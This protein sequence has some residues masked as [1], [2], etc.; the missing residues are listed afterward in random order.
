MNPITQGISQLG[1]NLGLPGMGIS[2][3]VGT[4]WSVA[5]SPQNVYHPPSSG[6]V[7]P[8]GQPYSQGL[9]FNPQGS[10]ANYNQMQNSGGLQFSNP[11][12][13]VQGAQTQTSSNNGNYFNTQQ[14]KGVLNGQ[15]YTDYNAY[16]RAGGQPN[17]GGIQQVNPDDINNAYNEASGFYDQLYNQNADPTV[18]QNYVDQFT[19]PYDAESQ[20]LGSSYQQ[21]QALNQNQQSQTRQ[22]QLNAL[23]A[24]KKQYNELAQGVQQRYGGSNSAGEFANAFLGRQFQQNSGNIQNTTGQNLQSL[25]TQAGNLTNQY[26]ANLKAL[27]DQKSAALGQAQTAFQTRLDAINQARGELAQNK[28]Q[29]KLQALTDYKNTVNSFLA[30]ATQMQQQIYAQHQASLDQLQNTI[31]GYQAY[32]RTPINLQGLPQSYYSQIGQ[33]QGPQPY[34]ATPTGYSGGNQKYDPITGQ[35]IA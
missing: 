13:Q 10:G 26:Q 33:S 19:K 31:A 3:P 9:Q 18:R 14:N 25:Y 34:S 22:D 21:G 20:V 27:E 30:Q 35:P 32:T 29:A 15:Q 28:A 2:E 24:A 7:G 12:G 17:G 6:L 5:Q 16:L 23:D 4:P 11:Q 8:T 1:Y